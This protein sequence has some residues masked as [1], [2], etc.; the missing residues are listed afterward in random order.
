MSHCSYC[1]CT[2]A[3]CCV[4]GMSMYAL[5]IVFCQYYVWCTCEKKFTPR[6]WIRLILFVC[7]LHIYIYLYV[8]SC[9][10]L[11]V[12]HYFGWFQLVEC[13]LIVLPSITLRLC[14]I[15]RCNMIDVRLCH[16]LRCTMI[17]ICNLIACFYFHLSFID[18]LK[19]IIFHYAGSWI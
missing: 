4:P 12:L 5:Y 2:T 19:Y 8:P 6:A 17:D 9:V 10:F 15:L 16:I 1:F 11:N 18:L 7:P 13:S 3:Y 14:H